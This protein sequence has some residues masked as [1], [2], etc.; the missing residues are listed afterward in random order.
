[1]KPR[2]RENHA[3]AIGFFERAL[4]RFV[5]AQG[6][7]AD[8]LANRVANGMTNSRVAVMERAEGLIRQV[9]SLSPHNVPAHS[10]EGSLLYA[11]NRYQDAC[12]EFAAVLAVNPNSAAAI[13]N[14]G[15][16]QFLSGSIEDG[17]PSQEQA[18]RH[19]PRDISSTWVW[20]YRIGVAHLLRMQLEDAIVWLGK[21]SQSNP[22]QS[23]PHACLAATYA[24]E[25]DTER[26]SRELAEARRLGCR[27]NKQREVVGRPRDILEACCGNLSQ[28]G[29]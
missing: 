5:E 18:I 6:L 7:L 9:L 2:T 22:S 26:A 21:A 1:L 29:I 15:W 27:R 28:P 10:A 12:R 25:G 4:P 11:R 23:Y 16:C 8:A 17:I 13:G 3:A 14:F 24:L 19:S 20:Y